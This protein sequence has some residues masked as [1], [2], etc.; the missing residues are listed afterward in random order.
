MSRPIVV[1]YDGS[2]HADR[3]LDRAAEIAAA[4]EAELVIVSVEPP[5]LPAPDEEELA[6][7]N[8]ALAKA[9]KRL[10]GSG[11]RMRA[12]A[13]RGE[14]ADEIIRVAKEVDAELIV[15][16]TRGLNLLQRALLGSVSSD[17][18]HHADQDVL[19]VR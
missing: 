4:E 15:V 14:P 8:E 17:L 7:A 6:Q 18:I 3:A 5:S 9:E 16:G 13:A 2:E 19:V 11:V 1:G 12:V 10:A